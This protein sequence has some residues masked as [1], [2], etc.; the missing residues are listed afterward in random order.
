MNMNIYAKCVK[1]PNNTNQDMQE[2]RQS[3]HK[4]HFLNI[5]N[6]VTLKIRSRSPKSNH[7]FPQSWWCICASLVKFQPLVALRNFTKGNNSKNGPLALTFSKVGT[8]YWYQCVTKAFFLSKF[9]FQS[10]SVTLKM[11]SKSPKSNNFF[12]SS[13]WSICVSLNKFHL[14]IHEIGCT[15]GSFLEPLLCSDLENEVKVTEI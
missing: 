5:Y 12:P 6:V 4:A 1:I 11:R 7:F 3:A 10:V 8:P 15:Q 9:E 2:K 14:M 13:Q